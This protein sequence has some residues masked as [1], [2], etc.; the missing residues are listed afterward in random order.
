MG[1][2]LRRLGCLCFIFIS[3]Q[4]QAQ[5]IAPRPLITR[6]IDETQLT[7]VRG[8]THPLSR[9]QFDVG[10]AP[11]DLPMDRMLLVLK[12]SPSRISRCINFSTTSRTRPLRI[13]TSGSR[14]MNLAFSSGPRARTCNW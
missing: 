11:P 8:S 14:R 7:P 10:I 4:L 6:P 5:Q 3:F 2:S 12:R 13:T 9:P 1:T